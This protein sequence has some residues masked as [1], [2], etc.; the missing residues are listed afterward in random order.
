MKIGLTGMSAVLSLGMVLFLAACGQTPAK[1]PGRAAAN[2]SSATNVKYRMEARKALGDKSKVLL[3]GDLAHNG[4]I[5][6][7]VVKRLLNTPEK[8]KSGPLISAAAI[9]ENDSDAWHE[10]FLADEHLKNEKGFLSGTP[11]TSVSAW[12][13]QWAQQEDGLTMFFTPVQQPNGNSSKRVEVRWNPSNQRYQ[14]LDAHS[15]NFLAELPSLEPPP[16]FRMS[17]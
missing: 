4:H 13:M 15:R 3:S 12:R 10:V 11:L 8:A 17:R 1:S 14:S 6:L 2:S 7:L 16:L 9:L 5:Q